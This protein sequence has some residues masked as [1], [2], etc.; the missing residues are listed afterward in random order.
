[1][2][3]KGGGQTLNRGHKTYTG[4]VNVTKY[5]V[6]GIIRHQVRPYKNFKLTH[7]THLIHPWDS[8]KYIMCAETRESGRVLEETA[9]LKEILETE[10][11][12]IIEDIELTQEVTQV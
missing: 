11:A 3:S 1:M 7:T 8:N 2:F 12:W 6:G 10:V 5:K 9:Y 4:R